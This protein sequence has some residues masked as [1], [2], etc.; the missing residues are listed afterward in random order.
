VHGK[1]GLAMMETHG[2][3]LRHIGVLVHDCW[4]LRMDRL[5]KV[6]FCLERLP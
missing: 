2:V 1:R 5:W 6:V 4:A 3:L